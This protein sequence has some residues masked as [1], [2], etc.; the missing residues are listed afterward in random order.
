MIKMIS[1]PVVQVLFVAFDLEDPV[2]SQEYSKPFSERHKK[3]Q[4]KT[5]KKTKNTLHQQQK[6]KKK[7]KKKKKNS[8]YKNFASQPEK[9]ENSG[10]S[11]LV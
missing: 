2:D 3:Q 10:W 7:K 1:V 11:C 4:K 5:E 9:P 8:L 6:Q